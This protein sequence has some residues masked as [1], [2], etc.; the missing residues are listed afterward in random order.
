MAVALMEIG[1]IGVLVETVKGTAVSPAA[2]DAGIRVWDIGLEEQIEVHERNT[3]EAEF[4]QPHAIPG[5]RSYQLTFRSEVVGGTSAGSRPPMWQLLRACGLSEAIIV[6]TS[7]TYSEVANENS[8]VTVTIDVYRRVGATVKRYRLTGAMGNVRAVCLSDG[9]PYF[10]FTF[11]G[12]YNEP[13]DVADLLTAPPYVMAGPPP[14]V[15]ATITLMSQTLRC[16]GYEFDLGNKVELREDVNQASGYL[17]AVVVDRL[18]TLAVTP[19]EELAA[20]VEWLSKKTT[21]T[22]GEFIGSIGSVAGNIFRIRAPAAQVMAAGFG[23]RGTRGV[24]PLNLTCRKLANAGGDA[25]T[26]RFT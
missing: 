7:V 14:V 12:V 3:V 8:Q 15:S 9:V 4:S 10:E 22:V 1:Q 25:M 18:P 16:V 11:L 5:M 6:P 21:P 20:T 19:E 26:L 2:V 24:R 23:T 13:A 17:H